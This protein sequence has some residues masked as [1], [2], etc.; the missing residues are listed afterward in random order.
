MKCEKCDAHGCCDV[1]E[2]PNACAFHMRDGSVRC[3]VHGTRPY[4]VLGGD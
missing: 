4:Y 2:D 3:V 1:C